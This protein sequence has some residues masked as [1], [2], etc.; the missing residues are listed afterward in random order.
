MG[1]PTIH[2]GRG[3]RR[4]PF[5]LDFVAAQD[6]HAAGGG[7]GDQ[8]GDVPLTRRPR[9]T[10]W[11]PSTSLPDQRLREYACINLRREVSWT[12]IPS[13]SLARF[14]SFDDSEQV[15]SESPVARE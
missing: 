8:A 10:G 13:M 14:Q 3:R 5:D 7:A 6:F 9:L 11:K 1:L 2:Y 15:E 12:R 4:C